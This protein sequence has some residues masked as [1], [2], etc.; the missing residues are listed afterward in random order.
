MGSEKADIIEMI[1]DEKWNRAT[2]RID[3]PT[4]TFEQVQAAIRKF[5]D[6]MGQGVSDRNP[7]NFFKDFVRNSD[8]ANKDWPQ[9]VLDRGY[10]ARQKTGNKTVF[11]FVPL[12]PDQELPFPPV[13]YP[14]DLACPIIP[15]QTLSMPQLARR[16]GG[17]EETW[18]I[19]VAVQLR[20]IETQLSSNPNLKLAHVQH[21][22]TGVKQS[23]S[24]IDALY[25]AEHE[26]GSNALVTVEAKGRRDDILESQL[27]AQVEA[28]RERALRD[29]AG[30]TTKPISRII[31]VGLKVV[32]DSRLYVVQFTSVPIDGPLTESLEFESEGL[33]ELRPPVPGIC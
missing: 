14:R 27:I 26:D 10:T 11:I 22:Q 7:A 15:I 16:L 13:P 8:R 20:L 30:R 24:E 4:V 28:V 23:K 5:N 12:E 9:S 6:K 33:Y 31:P 1:F 21:L 3:D 25:L 18:L 2:N 32:G 29:P 19:Q 17:R